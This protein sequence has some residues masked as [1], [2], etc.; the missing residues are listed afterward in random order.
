[1]AFLATRLPLGTGS[2][3]GEDAEFEPR[4][5][6]A[7]LA[8]VPFLADTWKQSPSVSPAVAAFGSLHRWLH[9][10]TAVYVLRR[11]NT[12]MCP[13]KGP[14]AVGAGVLS[15][16]AVRLPGSPLGGGPDGWCRAPRTACRAVSSGAFAASGGVSCLFRRGQEAW[17][18]F[19]AGPRRPSWAV[20]GLAAPAVAWLW[21]STGLPFPALPL[22]S[23]THRTR[24]QPRQHRQR[25]SRSLPQKNKHPETPA[26]PL[27][28]LP[29]PCRESSVVPVAP[30]G[31]DR[32]CRDGPQHR[33]ASA[34]CPRVLEGAG[35]CGLR[36]GYLALQRRC[37]L[38]PL[39]DLR[40]NCRSVAVGWQG[41]SGVLRNA[42]G[43]AA[44]PSSECPTTRLQG[45]T[46]H[47]GVRENLAR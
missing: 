4:R 19:C 24:S 7:D 9:Q 41:R 35:R 44:K 15:L 8:T 18:S 32:A 14:V 28:P 23:P 25:A 40:S 45:E 36:R 12:E 16:V 26:D 11:L 42:V 20:R 3:G 34:A 29:V 1:M 30:A 2:W 21:C 5:F 33:T 6:A 13:A 27:P 37:S 38:R 43:F 10:Q 31:S 22:N 47:C 46:K 17:G 39:P